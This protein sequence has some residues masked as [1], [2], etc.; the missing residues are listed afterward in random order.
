MNLNGNL[1]GYYIVINTTKFKLRVFPIRLFILY[2]LFAIIFTL[3][4][5]RRFGV[6][7][8]HAD[9]VREKT[10][11]MMVDRTLVLETRNE[12]SFLDKYLISTYH[13]MINR[14]DFCDNFGCFCLTRSIR[15][16]RYPLQFFHC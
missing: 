6:L 9:N 7:V 1:D 14:N 15:I 13:A 2:A 8:L 12:T 10:F 16:Y 3:I 4:T 11:H 5:T